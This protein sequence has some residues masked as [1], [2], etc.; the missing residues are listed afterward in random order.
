[1][2]PE[3][4][5]PGFVSTRARELNAAFTPDGDELYFT[6]RIDDRPTLMTTRWLDGVWT[7]PAIAGFS[8]VFSDVDPFVSRDGLRLY[9][10]S[11]RPVDGTGE[12]KDADLWYVEREEA[13]D[14]GEP[15][16]LEDLATAGRD[17]YYTSLSD[18]G[19]LY[20]SIF[21]QDGDGD[22]Y[23][24]QR[25]NGGFGPAERVAGG[26]STE[27]SEHDPFVAPDG[28]YLIFTS[29]RSGGHGS[30]DLYIS[31]ADQEGAW[32]E[33]VN[34]GGSINSAHYDFCAMLSP[35]GEYLFWTSR[36]D[37]Y[38]VDSEVIERLRPVHEGRGAARA[39]R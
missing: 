38:W 23:R 17:D 30:A 35:D 29:D 15:V 9:F 37:I 13:G 18:D 33:P 11:K 39:D 20:F 24:A 31:F 28:S 16:H 26:V 12:E 32:I 4:F 22:I 36:N 7:P 5:A 2:T 25:R 14:W 1:M 10:S 19:A 8:G 27:D 6:R 34:L 3:L 21:D